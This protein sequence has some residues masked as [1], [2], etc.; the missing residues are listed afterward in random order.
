MVSR[1]QKRGSLQEKFQ[2][3][4]SITNSHAENDTSII[5]DASKYI[6]KLKQKVERFNQDPTAEQSS[7]EPTDPKTPM[8]T[9]ETLDKGF[10]INVFSGKNQ[11]G[12]LVS[13]LEAFEDIGL[14]VL[15][16]RASCT[17]SF[18]LHAMGL[19]RQHL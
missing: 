4:R 19:E 2:L 11:P 18:S 17:D 10:M 6:Q 7:S 13:V 9:V 12:M 5:M 15:E 1:E 14:N 3:L 16:A 8:V